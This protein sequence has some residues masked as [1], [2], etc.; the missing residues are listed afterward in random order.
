[1]HWLFTQSNS[2]EKTQQRGAEVREILRNEEQ[3]A[4]LE[5][6]FMGFEML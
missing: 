6:L 1:M 2:T 4:V 5:T 3:L